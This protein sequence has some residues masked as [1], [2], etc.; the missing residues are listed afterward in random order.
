M[1]TEIIGLLAET[2]IHPGAGQAAGAIDLPVARERTTQYP[3]IAGSGMKGALLDSARSNGLAEETNRLFGQQDNAGQVLISDA[4]L[5]LLPVRSLASSYFWLT[6]PYLLERFSRDAE[7][8]GKGIAVG[9]VAPS[10]DDKVLATDTGD[11]FLEERLFSVERPAPEA[12]ITAIGRLVPRD[13]TRA[14]LGKQLAVITDDAFAWFAKYALPV[15]ARNV[16]NEDTKTSKNL[17]Y[18]E[19]LPPDTLMYF[20]VGERANGAAAEIAAHLAGRRY[21]QTG[22]N[23]TVGQGWFAVRRVEGAAS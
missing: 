21:L 7:R 14:R 17:W 3:V 15:Q 13:D 9:D 10:S 2:Y 23:E 16:L 11:I 20:V 12:L 5:L 6:C 18:E 4:R 22:G 19:A 1:T 8:A